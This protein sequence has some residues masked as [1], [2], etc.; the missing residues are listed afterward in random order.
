MFT[1]YSSKAFHRLATRCLKNACLLFILDLPFSN[2]ISFPQA[3][4]SKEAVISDYSPSQCHSLL[5]GLLNSLPHLSLFISRRGLVHLVH[6]HTEAVNCR[7]NLLH[8]EEVENIF[9]GH[10]SQHPMLLVM[11][12]TL[13]SCPFLFPFFL[14]SEGV[15]PM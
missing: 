1:M 15:A 12:T 13:S 10:V 14:R 6:F 9:A 5:S 8:Q 3:L 11:V 7:R 4:V 2:F